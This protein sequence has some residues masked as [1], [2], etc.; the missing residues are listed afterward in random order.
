MLKGE[1]VGLRAIEKDDLILLRNWRNNADFR[2]HFREHREL[3]L[4]NQEN[5][6]LKTV[7]NPNDFMFVIINLKTLEPIGA[8]GLLYTNW[9]IRSAD[10]SFYI[11]IDELYIDDKFAPDAIRLLINYGFNNLNL[12]KIWME[13]YEYDSKKLKIFQELFKFQIDGKLRKNAFENGVYWDSYIISLLKD[14]FNS[15]KTDE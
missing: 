10:F 5:W 7:N 2:K 3:N 8:A 11:G 13:L 12:N 4:A 14:E 9:I 6:F 1:F 15:I